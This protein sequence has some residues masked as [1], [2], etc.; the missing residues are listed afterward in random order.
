MVGA[1]YR[2]TQLVQD[3]YLDG[4]SSGTDNQRGVTDLAVASFISLSPANTRPQRSIAPDL[5]L[6]VYDAHVSVLV[7]FLGLSPALSCLFPF[8]LAC[9]RAIEISLPFS[10]ICIH[11]DT[12][13]S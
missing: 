8:L 12:L 4:V 3:S 7:G 5:L 10:V 11:S 2:I 1:L 6:S 9:S 13:H